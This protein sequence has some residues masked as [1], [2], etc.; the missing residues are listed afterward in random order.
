MNP[1]CINIPISADDEQYQN[2]SKTCF[3][4]ERSMG[5][6]ESDHCKMFASKFDPYNTW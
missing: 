4:V 6:V 5:V 1:E 2:G 3:K